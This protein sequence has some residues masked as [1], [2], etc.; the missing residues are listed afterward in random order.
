MCV[1]VCVCVGVGV[2]V[3]VLLVLGF[4]DEFYSLFVPLYPEILVSFFF[5]AFFCP[6]ESR[7]ALSSILPQ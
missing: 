5:R 4:C 6:R 1:G 7:S 2:G 3:G